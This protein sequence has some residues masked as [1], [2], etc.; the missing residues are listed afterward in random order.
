MAK[1]PPPWAGMDPMSEEAGALQA[2]AQ[3]KAMEESQQGY[4]ARQNAT[5]NEELEKKIMF[6]V[7][8]NDVRT[9]ARVTSRRG[10]ALGA[11]GA[12]AARAQRA[13]RAQHHLPRPLPRRA[14]P[15][16]AP[17]AVPVERFGVQGAPESMI[18]LVNLKNI[19]CRQLPR[20][21]KEYIARL[22]LDRSRPGRRPKKQIHTIT[23]KIQ[24]P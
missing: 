20:M 6:K 19:F 23:V 14:S 3:S 16:L 5:K 1:A 2:Q 24:H 15:C 13:Q 9:R 17:L 22:V 18:Y 7:I 12:A 11:L 8:T 4:I 10:R 21:P